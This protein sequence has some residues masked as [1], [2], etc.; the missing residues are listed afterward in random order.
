MPELKR[1][2]QSGRMN[3]DLDERLVPNGEYRDALNIEVSTSE[4]SDLGTLQTVLGNTQIRMPFL[5]QYTPTRAYTVGSIVNDKNDKLYWFI[6]DAGSD[7]TTAQYGDFYKADMILEYNWVIGN[8]LPVVVDVY[9]TSCDVLSAYPMAGTPYWYM[10]LDSPTFWT[11]GTDMDYTIYPGM[12]VSCI[13]AAGAMVF[14]PGTLVK[15]ICP[16]LR[17]IAV[18]NFPIAGM[19]PVPMSQYQINFK[20]PKR[21]LNFNKNR[22]ISGINIVDD[23][24]LWTDNYSEPK[25]VN[26]PL[27]TKGSL[28]MWEN[29]AHD[30]YDT[31]TNTGGV[32]VPGC[33]T[34]GTA[35]PFGHTRLRQIDT[36]VGNPPNTYIDY[37]PI[38]EEHTTVIR[39]SPAVAPVL[40][41]KNT[42]EAGAI[43]AWINGTVYGTNPFIDGDGNIHPPSHTI[44][45]L[46]FVGVDLATVSNPS[47]SIDDYLT[48]T[49]QGSDPEITIRLQVVGF[50]IGIP[51]NPNT[52]D[53]VV[54]SYDA[55]A[56]RKDGDEVWEVEL[57][58]IDPLFQFKFPRFATRYKYEDGEYSA[59]SPFTEVAFLPDKFDYMP[60]EGYNLGMVNQLR[61][62]AIKDF[63]HE[64]L[65]PE[66]V[67]AIDILYKESNSPNVYSVKTIKRKP[68]S[69][70]WDSWNAT[71]GVS[72]E[73]LKTKGFLRITSEM[74]H[75]M[76]PSNQLLRPW[77]NVPRKALAQ[78]ITGNRLVYGNYLQNYNLENWGKRENNI[79]VELKI[80][81]TSMD[82][83]ILAPAEHDPKYAWQRSTQIYDW[84]SYGPAKSIKTLRTYQVGVIYID[85]YGRE[86]PVFSK[87]KSG[88][89]PVGGDSTVIPSIYIE[90]KLA[91]KA[92]MLSVN[93]ASTVPQWAKAFK[94]FIKETSNEYYNLAMDRWYDAEDDNIWLSFPSAERNKVDEE[95]FL[96]LKKG[97]DNNNFVPSP[98]RYK[99]IAI[100]N[101]APSFIKQHPINKGVFQ[102]DT[103]GSFIGVVGPTGWPQPGSNRVWVDAIQQ[104]NQCKWWDVAGGGTPGKL[105]GDTSDF[106]FRFR[107]PTVF[108]DWYRVDE[109]K[110]ITPTHLQITSTTQFGSELSMMGPSFQARQ[111]GVEI[112][113]VKRETKNKPE[114]EGRFFVKIRKD[115][116]LI[117]T[118]INQ[119]AATAQYNTMSSIGSCYVNPQARWSA[120]NWPFRQQNANGDFGFGYAAEEIS[121]GIKHNVRF[122]TGQYGHYPSAFAGGGGAGGNG[123]GYWKHISPSTTSINGQPPR[124]SGWFIDKVEAFRRFKFTNFYF[125]KDNSMCTNPSAGISKWAP[126]GPPLFGA[127]YG[128][129]NSAPFGYI[130]PVYLQGVD[131]VRSGQ[132]QLT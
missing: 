7:T 88:A 109:V 131:G 77:D 19:M 10:L 8:I 51:P 35:A 5:S 87:S 42:Q 79:D 84:G 97:H 72:V 111:G 67:V 74:I 105:E 33:G 40:E 63:V 118:I 112:E 95:T 68:L 58:D 30:N 41:M 29:H 47:F 22:H 92:N 128:G 76:L 53:V 46:S 80:G 15:W 120:A 56:N 43:V 102:D 125:G 57:E 26:I 73:N 99:I 78:E 129:W 85:D 132:H 96:I 32:Y 52:F 21:V 31:F 117:S 98:A 91:N 121:V 104:A 18:D 108:S 64:R 1:N 82:V 86:T 89:L 38:M 116:E 81:V 4:G 113:M 130:I 127:S 60:K 62:L 48:V 65:L 45:G 115:L 55:G 14:P 83:G 54:I 25:R 12:E 39:R 16:L 126:A 90:K 23:L 28:P 37:G 6:S 44:Y 36:S 93:I 106:W 17:V 66:D 24:L 49:L 122:G 27:S 20:N 69:T 71:S 103:A 3:K 75:A 11:A 2:F 123:Q 114:F 107:L 50:T 13:N 9:H 101:E 110:L 70:S 100:E 119:N 94:F 61:S 34:L 124:P 59:F